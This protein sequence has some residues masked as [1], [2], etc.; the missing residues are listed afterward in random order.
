MKLAS[1]AGF[2]LLEVTIASGMMALIVAATTIFMQ[3]SSDNLIYRSA[4]IEQQRLYQSLRADIQN[5]D[6]IKYSASKGFGGNALLNRCLNSNAAKAQDCVS[7]SAANQV[8]FQLWTRRGLAGI[9]KTGPAA[10]SM[11]YS[12]NGVRACTVGTPHCPFWRA[13]SYFWATCPGG[14]TTCDQA[15][16]IHVRYIVRPVRSEFRGMP[17][18][19][20][21]PAKEFAN[22]MTKYSISHYVIKGDSQIADRQDCPTGALMSGLKENG[23]IKCKCRGGFQQVGNTTPIVC[24][25]LATVCRSD[26]R[27]KGRK[28]DGSVLCVDQ[29]PDCKTIDFADNDATCPLGGWLEGIN[30]GEC[31]PGPKTK[32][33]TKRGIKCVSNLGT[34]CHY[35][36]KN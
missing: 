35:K 13:E 10:A 16:N 3:Q 19:A 29:E 23:T 8:G 34:C 22:N 26:Q 27:I 28:Q 18:P 31:R 24:Q 11:V 21:P 36:E 20:M 9:Q 7:T 14:S 30:F 25:A 2:G 15:S 12:L 33:G 1:E 17:I 6:K 5:I 32:K 4:K